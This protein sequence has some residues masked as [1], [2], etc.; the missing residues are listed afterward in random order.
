LFFQQAHFAFSRAVP[1]G[2]SVSANGLAVSRV[3]A[4]GYLGALVE[5]AV[6]SAGRWYAEWVIEEADARCLVMLGVTDLT[7]APPA[8]RYMYDRPG[9][10]MYNCYSSMAFPGSR[11]WG[12]TGRRARGDRVG[13]LVARGSM[14]VFVNGA[15]LGPGPMATDL[16][17]MVRTARIDST[18]AHVHG[19]HARALAAQISR[20]L[21]V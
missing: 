11:A 21:A 6:S 10:R 16:P 1:E 3:G 20:V 14:W 15:Q 19:Q 2:V 17:H 7:A 13:L 18:H 4:V 5:P 12:A 9:S 8:G